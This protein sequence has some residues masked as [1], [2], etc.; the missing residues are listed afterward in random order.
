M[1]RI[2][3]LICVVLVAAIAGWAW[4]HNVRE[5]LMTL[6]DQ[7]TQIRNFHRMY[8]VFPSRVVRHGPARFEFARDPRMLDVTYT[9]HGKQL[10]L[11]E[12]LERTT[13]MGFLVVKDDRIVVERYF[14]GADEASRFTSW[15]MAKSFVSALIGVAIDEGHIAGVDRLITDYVPELRGSGYDGAAISDV[16]QMSSGVKF[17]EVYDNV[18]SDISRMYLGSFLFGTRIDDYP[19]GVSSRSKPGAKFEYVSV[20]TQ[21][22]GMLLA[23]TTGKRLAAY[24]EEKLW[25]PLGMESDAYWVTDR[26]GDAGV[27]Y[28]FCCLNATLRDYAKFGRLFLRRGSWNGRQVVSDAWVQQSVTPDKPSLRLTG[29]DTPWWAPRDWDIG[30]Q[31][32]W[33]VPAGADGEFTA[34]GVWG[35]YLYVNPRE[36]V[37]IVK[38]SVDPDFD[39]DLETIAAFRGVSTALRAQ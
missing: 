10:R 6:L 2:A 3:A 33:W 9:F 25:Q 19:A 20:D 27:E 22:L 35:Q 28:A 15:S 38:T 8:E 16:L 24:L 21:A 13:T 17:D 5:R 39:R 14:R 4:R 18:F 29:A 23:R 12:F 1:K 7:K 36:R 37:V 11:D 30:Y 31:Y 32:Q 26:D 34:I